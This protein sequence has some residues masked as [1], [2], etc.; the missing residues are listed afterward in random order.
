MWDGFNQRKF[1]RLNLRCEIDIV[2]DAQSPFHVT[3]E[4]IGVG[5]VCVILDKALERFSKCHLRLDVN[6]KHDL[7]CEGKIVW[8]V[9]TRDSKSSKKRYDTGIEFTGLEPDQLEKL[10]KYIENNH[11]KAAAK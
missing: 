6:A 7:E 9:P 5:G 10:R 2:S 4:N 8:I 3:T 11:K 1:P